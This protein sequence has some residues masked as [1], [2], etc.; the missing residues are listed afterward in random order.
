[1]VIAAPILVLSGSNVN[2]TDSQQRTWVADT[3]YNGGE[4]YAN[5]SAV[6][7]GTADPEIYR[8]MRYFGSQTGP[9]NSYF[10][11]VSI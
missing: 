2:A 4:G 6:I 9:I 11:Q 5:P 3:T 1:M 7:Y 8:S 10:F